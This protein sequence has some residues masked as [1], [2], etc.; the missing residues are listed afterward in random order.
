MVNLPADTGQFQ[1]DTGTIDVTQDALSIEI[2]TFDNGNPEV[3]LSYAVPGALAMEVVEPDRADADARPVSRDLAGRRHVHHRRGADDARCDHGV[4]LEASIDGR[5]AHGHSGET[6]PVP[7][8]A[9]DVGDVTVRAG[10][11]IG[12]Y[13]LSLNAGSA[14]QVAAITT[15]G[16]QAFD[17]GDLSAADLSQYDVLVRAEPGQRRLLVHVAQQPREGP[18]VH[19]GR[20]D[21]R[22]PR[23]PRVDRGEHAARFTGHDRAGL[24][25][26]SEHRHRGRLD[27]GDA[28]A[29]TARSPTTRSTTGTRRATGGSTRRRSRPAGAASSARAT[30]IIW[31]STPT[32]SGAA[33]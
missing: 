23:S 16:L 8:G 28:R 32:A 20:R 15:A 12:Y 30:R 31:C 18:P 22:L 1:E 26:R 14:N 9:T 5:N 6:A 29:R 3:Q 19:R 33:T 11:R 25:R 24:L 27:A 13:D 4:R 7:G 2:L 10:G 21:A 17:V